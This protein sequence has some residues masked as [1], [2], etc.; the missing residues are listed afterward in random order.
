GSILGT[1]VIVV[2]PFETDVKSSLEGSHG[3]RRHIHS[4]V[5]T[6]SVHHAIG[7]NP[8]KMSPRAGVNDIFCDRNGSGSVAQTSGLGGGAGS[9]AHRTGSDR[10][11][12]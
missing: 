6:G 7:R 11:L 12:V 10:S 8:Q 2:V 1:T 4:D 9:S 3:D 5:A